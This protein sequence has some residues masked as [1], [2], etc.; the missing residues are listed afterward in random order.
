MAGYEAG[1]RAEEP[2]DREAGRGAGRIAVDARPGR[3]KSPRHVQPT[4]G[5]QCGG[6]G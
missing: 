1:C 6:G 5:E 4:D 2:G 3:A